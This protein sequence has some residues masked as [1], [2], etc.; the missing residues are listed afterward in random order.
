M[1]KSQNLHKQNLNWKKICRFHCFDGSVNAHKNQ[2]NIHNTQQHPQ[3]KKT[4][5]K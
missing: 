2:A 5:H 1:V 4:T 3:T